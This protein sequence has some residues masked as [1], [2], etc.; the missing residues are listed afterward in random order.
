[1]ALKYKNF[2]NGAHHLPRGR[3]L[4]SCSEDELEEAL[5]ELIIGSGTQ[6]VSYWCYKKSVI[7]MYNS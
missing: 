4:E 7:F 6:A 1:M 2:Q 3:E 5:K